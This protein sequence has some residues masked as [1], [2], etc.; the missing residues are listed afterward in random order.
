MLIF[1]PQK[2]FKNCWGMEKKISGINCTNDC[3]R[4]VV[5]TLAVLEPL[6]TRRK[7]SNIPLENSKIALIVTFCSEYSGFVQDTERGCVQLDM[8]SE[9]LK[10]QM[11][12]T[13]I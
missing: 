10:Q 13:M 9:L 6:F 8:S 1:I 11:Q 7:E 12:Q 4:E 2:H 5:V 3:C